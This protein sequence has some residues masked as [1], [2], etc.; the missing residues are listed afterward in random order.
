MKYYDA[1]LEGRY[2][3]NSQNVD[4]WGNSSEAEYRDQRLVFVIFK[5]FMITYNSLSLS[6]ASTGIH[7]G[8][9]CAQKIPGGQKI[10]TVG[11]FFTSTP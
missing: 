6:G 4:P 5:Y 9:D 11:D 1:T 2:L 3:K 7:V 8:A 10:I